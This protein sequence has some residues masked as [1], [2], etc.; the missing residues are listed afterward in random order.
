MAEDC[1]EEIL[2]EVVECRLGREAEVGE[3]KS[4]QA[5]RSGW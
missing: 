2:G 3:V 4:Y 5:A 1:C